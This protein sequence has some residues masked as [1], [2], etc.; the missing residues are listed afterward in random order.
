MA[1]TFDP[2]KPPRQEQ[3]QQNGEIGVPLSLSLSD[4]S[5]P[6]KT[7]WSAF[8]N[9][10]LNATPP[11]SR[12]ASP[13]HSPR[14]GPSRFSIADRSSDSHHESFLEI[15]RCRRERRGRS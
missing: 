13:A 8:I 3:I 2:T 1:D 12:Q 14:L 15:G 4:H 5:D 7:S 6:P 9:S 11:R 10:R